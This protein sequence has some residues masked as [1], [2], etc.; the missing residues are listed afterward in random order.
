MNIPG[1]YRSVFL[2]SPT[3]S[4]LAGQQ[5]LL[6]KELSRINITVLNMCATDK[7]SYL[8]DHSRC[9]G[10]RCP[11]RTRWATWSK[12][13]ALIAGS[14][15]EHGGSYE[16]YKILMGVS[17]YPVSYIFGDIFDIFE[18]KHSLSNHIIKKYFDLPF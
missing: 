3:V 2:K 10:R 5:V 11:L 16:H 1:L 6:L 9:F 15:C 12:S 8:W 4:S 18:N 13:K 7:A 14:R 17:K